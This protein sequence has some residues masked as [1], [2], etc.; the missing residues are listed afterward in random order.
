MDTR[1]VSTIFRFRCP[2]LLDSPEENISAR[3]LKQSH[4]PP[5]PISRIK[6]K[7]RTNPNMDLLF[8]IVHKLVEKGDIMPFFALLRPET[9][10]IMIPITAILGGIAVAIVAII[11]AARKKELEHKERLTAIDKGMDIPQP[12]EKEKRPAYLNMR[13]W[14]LV[15]S[16]LGV[17]L[18][19]A[20]WVAGEAIAGVWGFLPLAMGVGLLIAAALEKNETEQ[21]KSGDRA[22]QP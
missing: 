3:I 12:K 4:P 18:T 22:G 20:L 19:V 9:L 10:A 8:T 17:A 5:C 7:T 14:G 2:S 11:M 21:K 15:L 1:L 6:F 13:P 16:C